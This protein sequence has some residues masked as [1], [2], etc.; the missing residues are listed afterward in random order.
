MINDYCW[1]TERYIFWFR[2]IVEYRSIAANLCG[3]Y[4]IANR[5]LADL[6]SRKTVSVW[7]AHFNPLIDT[8]LCSVTF[9]PCL[10]FW[11]FQILLALFSTCMPVL[12]YFLFWKGTCIMGWTIAAQFSFFHVSS[13]LYILFFKRLTPKKAIQQT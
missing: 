12:L 10:G 2:N 5:K 7:S 13:V 1:N 4:V 8:E 6:Y 9:S 3:T 11:Q